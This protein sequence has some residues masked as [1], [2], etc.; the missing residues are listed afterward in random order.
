MVL[1][2][3]SQ[4]SDPPAG[5][6]TFQLT[7]T[8]L[9]LAL[10]LAGFQIVA[11]SNRRLKKLPFV[12]E[13]IALYVSRIRQDKKST[14]SFKNRSEQ[15]VPGQ[16]EGSVSA[17]YEFRFLNDRIESSLERDYVNQSIAALQDGLT[18]TM[19]FHTNEGRI[20]RSLHSVMGTKQDIRINLMDSLTQAFDSICKKLETTE[21]LLHRREAELSDYL[22]DLAVADATRTNLDLQRNVWLLTKVAIAFAF[23][24]LVLTFLT[25]ANK[26]KLVT[27]VAGWLREFVRLLRSAF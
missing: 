13:S 6:H 23:L 11:D 27:G 18:N 19:L 25:D 21:K 15:V 22:R 3:L 16:P 5:P 20:S 26:E 8:V 2:D 1:V 14:N 4:R 24:S 12:S 9:D 7:K 17:A 10:Y